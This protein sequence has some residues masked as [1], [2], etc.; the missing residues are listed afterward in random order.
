MGL[1]AFPARSLGRDL[2]SS[3]TTSGL[4]LKVPELK[5]IAGYQQYLGELS[6]PMHTVTVLQQMHYSPC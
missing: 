3:E 5:M 2:S 4:N 6:L 1:S